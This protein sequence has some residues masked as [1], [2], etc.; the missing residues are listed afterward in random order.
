MSS[1]TRTRWV[2]L[3]AALLVVLGTNPLPAQQ[4]RDRWPNFRLLAQ[5][6]LQLA[7]PQEEV[8]R[9]PAL[10]V[11]APARLPESLLPLSSLPAAI[12][13]FDGEV[14]RQRSQMLF[15]DLAQ[16]TFERGVVEVT[17]VAPP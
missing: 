11:F 7:Q 5:Q 8:L 3:L 14:E 15:Q 9:L 10:K 13:R 17:H 6:E 16:A 12:Q 4:P 2:V 1:G